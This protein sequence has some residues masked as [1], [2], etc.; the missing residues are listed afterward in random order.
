MHAK[1]VLSVLWVRKDVNEGATTTGIV[2]EK[3]VCITVLLRDTAV[4]GGYFWPLAR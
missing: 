3:V 2:V 1:L 4:L